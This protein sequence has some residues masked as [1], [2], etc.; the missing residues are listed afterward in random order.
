MVAEELTWE[1]W[2]AATSV[3][4]EAAPVADIANEYVAILWAV[5]HEATPITGVGHWIPGLLRPA[6]TNVELILRFPCWLE[7]ETIDHTEIVSAVP[8][9]AAGIRLVSNVA[10]AT[11]QEDLLVID[12]RFVRP[13][14]ISQVRDQVLD[15]LRMRSRARLCPS[16]R[17]AVS[18]DE[19][20][21][22]HC[23]AHQGRSCTSCGAAMQA[24]DSFCAACG[25]PS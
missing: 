19:Q 7:R 16:C 11:P 8:E 9:G 13:D 4:D 12:S 10:A 5:T 6:D 23:G 25:R 22:R 17:E 15:G 14:E 18:L 21:C 1:T 24:Q 2:L 20:F 3:I